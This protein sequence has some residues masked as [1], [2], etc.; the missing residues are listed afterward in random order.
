MCWERHSDV[1][2]FYYLKLLAHLKIITG[3]GYTGPS[4]YI[5][6]IFTDSCLLLQLRKRLIGFAVWI[7]S[8]IAEVWE[9]CKLARIILIEVVFTDQRWKIR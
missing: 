1:R 5:E 2:E 6:V 9:T 3:L 8:Y 4:N 7:T